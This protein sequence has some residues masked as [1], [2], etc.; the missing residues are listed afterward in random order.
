[1]V[2]V[3]G[4]GVSTRYLRPSLARL[5]R[6]RAV[7]APDLPGF[8]RSERPTQ[9]LDVVEHAR[10]V[11]AWMDVIGVERAAL[12]A[13]SMGCQVAVEVAIRE[14]D[15]AA[16][17]VLVGPTA[18]PAARTLVRQLGR[19][20]LDSTREPVALNWVVTTDYLRAGPRRT[21][22]TARHM[23]RHRVEER[24]P[25][26]QA[27]TLVVRGERDPIVP[28]A[29]AA[30]AA[31]LAPRGRLAVVDRASHCAHFGWADAVVRLTSGFIVEHAY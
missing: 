5:A 31:G 3:H 27:P 24:L 1:M 23:L 16:C 11:S 29:W 21:L 9:A 17:L 6:E 18:D 2:G 25:L 12:F 7:Y 15:R 19:L 22:L 20:A 28:Q 8:G 10:F 30:Q 4:L 13:N 14:P 26:V